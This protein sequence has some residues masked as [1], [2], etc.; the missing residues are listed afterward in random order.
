LTQDLLDGG[1][2][3]CDAETLQFTNNPLIPPTRNL[4][5]EPNDQRSHLPVDRRST[6]LSTVRPP[7]RDESAVPTEQRGGRDEE[8]FPPHSWQDPSGRRQEPS[9]G[10]PKGRPLDAATEYRQLVAQDDDFK[11]LVLRRSEQ[12]ED[13]LENA[14]KRD[15]KKRY[16]HGAS[17]GS[18]TGALFYAVPI[19]APYRPRGSPITGTR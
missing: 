5:S 16:E 4:A 8:G 15:V 14:V 6:G 19:C 12:E 13:Q 1:R 18:T 11:F 2:R 3:D 9:V 17:E 7:F 10:R